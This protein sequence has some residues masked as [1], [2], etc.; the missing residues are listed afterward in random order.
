MCGNCALR[1]FP[2][3]LKIFLRSNRKHYMRTPVFFLFLSL[4]A[5]SV[6]GQLVFDQP[7]QSS[8]AKP[9]Q[10]S[11]VAKYRFTNIGKESVTIENVQTSC[12]CTTAGLK[13]TEYAPG[14]SGEIEAKFTFGGR[15]GKQEKAI[16]VTTSQAREK[17]ILLRLLVD[18]ED[19]IQIQPELVLWRAGEQLESKKIKITVA[20]DASIK[21]L[22]VVSDNP[23]IRAQLSEVKPGKEYEIQITPTDVSQPIGARLLIRTNYPPQNPRTRYAY[24]RVK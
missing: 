14:E 17:P 23:S 18:I 24:A 16:L 20:D 1:G 3:A 6:Y 11:I 4:F 15:S 7:E 22:S 21:I 13:K 5:G 9:E 19:Q 2:F 10:E 12:G 8:K